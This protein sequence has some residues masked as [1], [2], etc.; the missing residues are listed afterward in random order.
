MR[1]PHL[2]QRHIVTF[3]PRN[4]RLVDGHTSVMP[5]RTLVGPGADPPPPPLPPIELAPRRR[6]NTPLASAPPLKK[7]TTPFTRLLENALISSL[8]SSSIPPI[9]TPLHTLHSQLEQN[10]ELVLPT[11]LP[12]ESSP[13]PA[14]RVLLDSKSV[15]HHMASGADQDGIVVVAHAIRHAGDSSPRVTLSLG[16]AI[17]ASGSSGSDNSASVN[18][19]TCCHTLQSAAA[20]L[21]SDPSLRDHSSGTF[22]Y[23][24]SGHLFPVKAI[25]SSLPSVDLAVMELVEMPFTLERHSETSDVSSS[26][27]PLSP[28]PRLRTLPLNPY[29]APVG[30]KV[31]CAAFREPGHA[32]PETE[33]TKGS[34]GQSSYWDEGIILEY[35]DFAGRVAETGTYDDL[36]TMM[37]SQVP[38]QGASGGPIIDVSSGSV[39]GVVRGSVSR[40]GDKGARGFGTPS[41]KVFAL[42]QLPG[43]SPKSERQKQEQQQEELEVGEREGK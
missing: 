32:N 1:L 3:A 29:P 28:P 21:L 12:Y 38:L 11:E 22:V 30:T 36:S 13:A 42:F 35:A 31:A 34:P 25:L 4:A 8:E 15:N 33:T 23:T 40:Y 18:I 19:L 5:G 10:R 39:V 20:P 27:S 37:L 14:R 7:P 26:P 41:E 24:S 17:G 9:I 43:F 16:F 6:R 2:F